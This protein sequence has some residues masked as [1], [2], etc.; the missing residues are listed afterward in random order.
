[1]HVLLTRAECL[2]ILGLGRDAS[3]HEVRRAYR[4]LVLHC[5]PDRNPGDAASHRRFLEVVEARNRLRDLDRQATV[6][7]AAVPPWE[8]PS[9]AA[10][11]P[12]PLYPSW[13]WS[14]IVML[15]A[16]G[17]V[18][19]LGVGLVTFDTVYAGAGPSLTRGYKEEEAVRLRAKVIAL[20]SCSIPATAFM[21][22][23]WWIAHERRASRRRERLSTGDEG[24]WQGGSDDER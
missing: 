16:V 20:G 8:L 23:G 9:P 17:L 3:A 12:L 1:M 5:H 13:W 4:R 22:L 15:V 7:P 19:T 24:P 21:G 10:H 14:S 18:V 6:R 2:S 11:T